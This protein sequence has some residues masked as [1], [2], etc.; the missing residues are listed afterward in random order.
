MLL[1]NF[2]DFFFESDQI[3][4]HGLKTRKLSQLGATE[5]SSCEQ[6]QESNSQNIPSTLQEKLVLL[7]LLLSYLQGSKTSPGEGR[8]PRRVKKFEAP[9]MSRTFEALNFLPMRKS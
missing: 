9:G 3:G 5:F 8:L 6:F 1:Y 7:Q 2:A 4:S